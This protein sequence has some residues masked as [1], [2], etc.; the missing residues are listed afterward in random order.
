[1]KTFGIDDNSIFNPPIIPIFISKTSFLNIK[2]YAPNIKNEKIIY[3]GLSTF[4]LQNKI[5]EQLEKAFHKD[6]NDIIIGIIGNICM[7]KNQQNFID[8]VFYKCKDKYKN[9]KLMLVGKVHINLHIDNNYK[10]SIIIVG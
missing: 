1:L 7:R 3:N 4:F 10:N 9:I 2:Q 6:N 8:N 5:N